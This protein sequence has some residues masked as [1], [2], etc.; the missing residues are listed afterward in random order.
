MLRAVEKPCT[1]HRQLSLSR[2][3]RSVALAY[4]LCGARLVSAQ[5]PAEP[6]PE[7]AAVAP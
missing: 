2:R 1:P 5:T 3:A 6:E 7:P 4:A